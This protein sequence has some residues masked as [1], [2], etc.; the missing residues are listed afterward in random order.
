M[1]FNMGSGLNRQAGYVNVDSAAASQPDEVWNLEVTPWPW[2]D[3]CAEEIVFNH[4][5]EHMGG[6]PQV[7]LA[8][9]KEIY[10]IAAPGAVVRIHAPHPRHDNFLGDPTHVRPITPQ[11]LELFDRLLNEAWRKASAANTPL[12]FYLD[13]DFELRR[14][15]V[16]VDEPYRSRLMS[17]EMSAP[18]V[19][20]LLKTQYNIAHEFRIEL[21]AH[22]PPRTVD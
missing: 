17:G 12:S 11:M 22:K 21:V 16:L 5:L 19:Q 13:V 8:I 2:P 15:E 14:R 4:S 20:E 6:D 9:M 7:F 18:Q 3:S 1:K 10:R